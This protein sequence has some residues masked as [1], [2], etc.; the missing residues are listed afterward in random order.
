[1]ACHTGAYLTRFEDISSD[2]SDEEGRDGEDMKDKADTSSVSYTE[3]EEEEADLTGSIS[4]KRFSQ[5]SKMTPKYEKKVFS[6]DYADLCMYSCPVCTE[7]IDTDKMRT[8]LLSRHNTQDYDLKQLQFST[9]TW[10]RCGICHK[11]LLFTRLKLRNH[12]VTE[13][14]MSIMDYNQQF[15]SREPAAEKQLTNDYANILKTLCKIC[16]KT[17]ETDHFR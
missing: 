7:D 8:H 17:V 11:E 4:K 2:E 13:H 1:M 12:V 3:S 6:S 14:A 5:G 16:N 10:H 9:K 15:M